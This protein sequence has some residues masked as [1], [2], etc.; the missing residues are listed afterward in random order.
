MENIFS[1]ASHKNCIESPTNFSQSVSENKPRAINAAKE[2]GSNPTVLLVGTQSSRTTVVLSMEA[3]PELKAQGWREGSAVR[4]TCCSCQR[5]GF[6]SQ[7]LQG[8]FQL[9]LIPVLGIL[10]L[11]PGLLRH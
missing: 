3:P 9:S 10:I 6:G 11:P 1:I 4:S 2:L 7:P 5:L 8:D